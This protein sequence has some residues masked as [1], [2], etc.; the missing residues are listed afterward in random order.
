VGCAVAVPFRADVGPGPASKLTF[1]QWQGR[2]SGVG[3]PVQVRTTVHGQPALVK[4]R[5]YGSLA[6]V[7]ERSIEWFEDGLTFIIVSFAQLRPSKAHT[8]AVLTASELIDVADG[9][10]M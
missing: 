4:V 2:A 5:A 1:G 9:L 10:R 3:I 6:V 7:E 8:K